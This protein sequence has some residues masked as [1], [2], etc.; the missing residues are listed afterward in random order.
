VVGQLGGF[1]GDP[2]KD[3]IGEGVHDAH[4]LARD[5]SVWVNLLQDL[6]D[7]DGIGLFPLLV[8]LGAL[9]ASLLHDRFLA[10][11]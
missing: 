9:L 6:V 11:L 7:V 8:T 3:V 10:S 2:L 1:V 4:G 5:A